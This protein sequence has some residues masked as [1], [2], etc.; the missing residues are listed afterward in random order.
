MPQHT[1][2]E[3]VRAK[4]PGIYDDFDDATLEAKVLAKY[5]VYQDLHEP[6]K[7]IFLRPSERLMQPPPEATVGA[8]KGVARRAVGLGKTV[9]QIPGVTPA[10]DWL[11]GKP[12]LSAAA[13]TAAD[14][15]LAP[16]TPGEALGQTIEQVGEFL[17]PLPSS[18][19]RYL[20]ELARTAGLTAAQGGSGTD[21]AL[22][23]GVSAVLPGAGAVRRTASGLGRAAESLVR[24]ALKPTVAAMSHIAGAS[25]TG[26]NAQ[27]Q[28]LV[29]FILDEK[30]A[31][32][33]QATLIIQ[34]AEAELQRVLAVKNAPTDAPRRAIRYLDALE[35]HAAKQALPAED[36]ATLRNAAAEVLESGLG[37]DVITM[38]PAPHPT[39][40]TPQG[41]PIMV[42]V[43]KTTRALRP[44]VQAAEALERA[45]ATSQWATKKQWGEQKGATAEASKAVERA[46]RDAVKAAVPE[47]RPLLARERQAIQAQTVLDRAGF[48]AM[49]RDVSSLGAQVIAAGEIAGGRIPTLAFAANW[50][51]NNQFRAGRWADTLRNAIDRGNVP[52]VMDIMKKLG[53]GMTAQ[54]RTEAPP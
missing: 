27:A 36:V 13:L 54:I 18:K 16:E 9:H 10:V 7:A 37:E 47:A 5:P 38:V 22:A 53:V 43:P 12:G 24:A 1:I 8:A 23:T 29:R 45:R 46:A 14:T 50:L 11:Y 42:L 6:S 41:T 21:V 20:A 49:N 48:R 33:E 15:T 26:L 51:R 25:R 32:A 30:I 40:V 35:R 2:A 52:L 28:R 44:D 31:T 17:V 4:F 19:V 34:G 39:L 3:R